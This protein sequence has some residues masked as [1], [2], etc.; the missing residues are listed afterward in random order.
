VLGIVW[1]CF[2]FA[3]AL[4]LLSLM[5]ASQVSEYESELAAARS[6]V[7]ELEREVEELWV[8]LRDLRGLTRVK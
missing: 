2:G 8:R 1:F 5:H 6:R 7:R 3:V 4:V